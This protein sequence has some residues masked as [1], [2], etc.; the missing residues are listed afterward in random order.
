LKEW[1]LSREVSLWFLVHV[2]NLFSRDVLSVM[3]RTHKMLAFQEPKM[4]MFDARRV[5]YISLDIA[6][7]PC[8]A[9]CADQGNNAKCISCSGH[10]DVRLRRNS[11]CH[12][13]RICHLRFFGMK[14]WL[15]R[16]S[17]YLWKE[18]LG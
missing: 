9:K 6:D 3:F 13:S 11:C 16:L 12:D 15:C 10:V 8:E 4:N 14:F 7:A 18:T 5:H 2:R 1:C 17:R